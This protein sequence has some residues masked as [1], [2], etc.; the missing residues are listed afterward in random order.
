MMERFPNSAYGLDSIEQDDAKMFPYM[1]SPLEAYTAYYFKGSSIFDKA[2][3]SCII[4]KKIF[5]EANGFRPLRMVGDADMWHRLSLQ[6][7]VVIMPHGIIWSRGH[8]ESES[9]KLMTKPFILYHYLLIRRKYLTNEDC[10]L[11]N[12]ERQRALKPIVRHQLKI[13]T[14]LF[15]KRNFETLKQIK[16]TDPSGYWQL[17]KLQAKN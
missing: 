9:G 6:Y 16:E 1:L 12:E 15:L 7:P 3:T 2:P 10:P 14:K 4:K 13:R 8:E 5:E 11:S 17:V